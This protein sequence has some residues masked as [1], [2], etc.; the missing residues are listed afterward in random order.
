[1]GV[2]E[3]IGANRARIIFDDFCVRLFL[4][5]K[6]NYCSDVRIW[7]LSKSNI[8][9]GMFNSKNL[10]WAVCDEAANSLHGWFYK[11][12][13]LLKSLAHRIEQCSNENELKRLCLNLENIIEKGIPLDIGEF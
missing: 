12:G 9:F 5:Y 8:L 2:I 1:M 13:D 4:K 3:S 10:Y 6:G 11:E 7:K